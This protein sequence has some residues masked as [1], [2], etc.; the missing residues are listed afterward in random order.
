MVC[1]LEAEENARLELKELVD[2]RLLAWKSGKEGNIRA[3]IASLDSVLWSKL[4]WPKIGM[5]ELVSEK[6]VKARYMKAIAKLHPD[7]VRT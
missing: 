2:S 3:L 5:S 7:K 4:D 1:T 6:Q